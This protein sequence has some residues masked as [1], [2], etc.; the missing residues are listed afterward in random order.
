MHAAA[1]TAEV[2]VGALGD[3]AQSLG[4][5]ALVLRDGDRFTVEMIG[6]TA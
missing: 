3:R 5:L 4:A 2:V 1:A 6:R